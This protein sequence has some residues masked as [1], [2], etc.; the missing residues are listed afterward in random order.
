MSGARPTDP[1]STPGFTVARGRA[2]D[3]PVSPCGHARAGHQRS[4]WGGRRSVP[5]SPDRHPGVRRADWNDS[6]VDGH[7]VGRDE[8]D[9][10]ATCFERYG[11]VPRAS[12][13]RH[14]EPVVL[15]EQV[16]EVP[17]R[18]V[19]ASVVHPEDLAFLGNTTVGKGHR[20]LERASLDRRGDLG[21]LESAVGAGELLREERG[22]DIPARCFR[23]AGSTV[24]AVG[25][26]VGAEAG[27]DCAG[28]RHVVGHPVVGAR[29]AEDLDTPLRQFVPVLAHVQI[30]GD[31]PDGRED[32]L[33]RPAE[34]AC[35]LDQVLESLRVV[36]PGLVALRQPGGAGRGEVLVR[37]RDRGDGVRVVGSDGG[38]RREGVGASNR[39]D[40]FIMDRGDERGHAVL[41]VSVCDHRPGLEQRVI[42]RRGDGA[43]H[44]G[45]PQVVLGVSPVEGLPETRANL[46]FL[47]EIWVVAQRLDLRRHHAGPRVE[48]DAIARG[49][50]FVAIGLLVQARSADDETLDRSFQRND[51]SHR[52]PDLDALPPVVDVDVDEL[53]AG[54]AVDR[55]DVPVLDHHDVE[56]AGVGQGRHM[57]RLGRRRA[58]IAGVR[59]RAPGHE[60]EPEVPAVDASVF[61][62]VA[63]AGPCAAVSPEGEQPAE[64]GPIDGLIAIKIREAGGIVGGRGRRGAPGGD[65]RRGESDPDDERD[66]CDECRSHVVRFLQPHHARDGGR[67]DGR[68]R[69]KS[70]ATDR[71]S[72]G[73]GVRVFQS[74]S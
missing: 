4:R 19:G 56:G 58:R 31:T 42:E 11:G 45:A 1:V 60:H 22:V 5:E 51:E 43:H 3:P 35:V 63:G 27:Q 39:V 73:G 52:H 48:C 23:M 7:G 68:P 65:A 28:A 15:R 16:V 49:H 47:R 53:L 54:R 30:V 24:A 62:E 10:I 40:P 50:R 32:L 26:D 71:Y 64:V 55:V 18:A 69:Q 25:N 8:I 74:V 33:G 59:N 57:E 6:F 72:N 20:H 44:D 29:E 70:F 9:R 21:R 34:R 36:V 67:S 41:R 12:A 13:A 46:T 2:S 38:M 17:G 66:S 37:G 61:I 14:R